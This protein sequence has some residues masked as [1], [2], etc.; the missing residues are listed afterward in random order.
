MIKSSLSVTNLPSLSGTRKVNN[1][2]GPTV[3]T[4]QLN[5]R[6]NTVSSSFAPT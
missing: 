5:S 6:S 3:G 4:S 1:D 2:A